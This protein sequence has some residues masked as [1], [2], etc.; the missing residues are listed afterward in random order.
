[1]SALA[2]VSGLFIPL[3]LMISG[4]WADEADLS[5]GGFICARPFAPVCVDAPSTYATAANVAGC[6][7]EVDRFVT[8]TVA[9]R[10][11]LQRQSAAR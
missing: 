8:A 9:Y 2:R 4:A 7:N 10:D 11:C 3:A 6:Q 5:L 1:M